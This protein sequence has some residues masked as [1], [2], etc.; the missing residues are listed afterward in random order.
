MVAIV[1]A[2][3]IV[4]VVVLFVY[5]NGHG[6]GQNTSGPALMQATCASLSGNITS[7]VHAASGGVGDH[8]YFLIVAADPPSPYAGFNGSYYVP[9]TDQWPTMKVHQGQTV[10][11]HVINCASGEAHGFAV[12]FYDENSI[13]S[14]QPGHSYDVTFTATRTGTFRVY[15]D[16][17][18]AIHPF[19]QNGALVVA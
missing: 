19:M 9:T 3:A 10:S 13:V 5:V 16:I 1:A 7:V 8:A 14:I 17:F 18:C 6:S 2:L 11:I 12:S 4:A 15:C